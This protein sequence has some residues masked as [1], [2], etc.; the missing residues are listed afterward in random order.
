MLWR[1]VSIQNVMVPR[2]LVQVLHPPHQF[3]YSTITMSR[4][5][6]EENNDSNITCS[7]YVCSWSFTV[8]NFFF[9]SKFNGSWVVSIK[10]NVNF[11]FQ[12]PAMFVFFAFL[13]RGLIKTCSFFW[14]SIRIQNLMMRLWL[15]NILHAPQEF[16]SPP[17]WNGC[18]CGTNIVASR[19]PSMVSPPCCI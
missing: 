11:K 5:S 15:V 3:Q 18:S 4:N 12:P 19:S 14:R 13:K 6:V 16:K 7:M 1:Y 8:Q 2:W 9:L 10:Q 17:F